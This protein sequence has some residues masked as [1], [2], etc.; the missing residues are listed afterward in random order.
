MK[1]TEISLRHPVA[2]TVLA[3]TVAVIGFFS[4][5]T[6][7]V[8]YLP[9]VTYPLIR[10]Q[11]WWRG[12]TPEDIETSIAEP[13]ER[14]MAT[15]ENLD[16][17]ESS[18]IE[19]MYTLLVNFGYGADVDVAY[20][21]V[22]AAMGRATRN[23]PPD[24][25][26]PLVFKADPSQLP[27]LELTV[28]SD[29]RNPVWLRDWA[30]HWLADRLTAVDGTAG[31]EVLGGLKREIR[32]LLDPLRLQA[33]GVDV[34]RVARVLFESN[35]ELFAGRV[36]VG[37][38]EFIARTVGEFT[39]IDEIENVVVARTPAGQEVRV[40]D[41]ARVEDSHEDSRIITRLDGRP[42]VKLR[43]LKQARANTVQV[44]RDV[45][46]RMDDLR[47]DIP[48]DI[49]VAI[50]E[51]QGD[52]VNAAIN[53][54]Q[55]SALLAALLVLVI[56]YLFLGRWRQIIVMVVALPLT[57][58]ACFLVM[59]LAGFSLNLFSLGGL[60][61]SLGVI[62]DNSIVVLENV[63]RRKADGSRAFALEGT[64]EVGTAVVAATITFLAIFLPFLFIP[65]LTALLFREL[66]LVI[67]AVVV[68][69]LLVALVVTPLISDRLLR[70]ERTGEAPRLTRGFDGFIR[71]L[72]G[73]YARMLVAV[74]RGRWPVAGVFL[75]L[76]ALGL[77]LAGRAG[78]E[79]LP[80]VDD[81]RVMVKVKMP[82]GT[83]VERVD[84]VMRSAER[85][86]ADIPEIASMFTLTG[87]LTR[88]LATYEIAEE[89]QIDI[90]LVPKG[91]RRVSSTEFVN[92][93][94]P[95]LAKVPA[96]G[97][98]VM[99][100]QPKT[101]GIRQVGEQ[102]VE[103]KVRG[104]VL[105]DIHAFAREIA[106]SLRQADGL[107][108]VS[109][110]LEIAKPE[111]RVHI[112][113][114]RASALGV[115][116]N[117]VATSLRTLVTG[118]VATRY[119]ENDEY[120]NIRVLVPEEYVTCKADMENLTVTTATGATVHLRDIAEVHRAVGPVEISREDQVKQVIVR[121][122]AEAI[123]V[124][125]A[126]NRAEG[127]VR[128]L[129]RP[130][131]IEYSM[132]G[133]AQMIAENR[134][135]MTLLV[136][137]ALLFA[138]TVLAVQFESLRLPLLILL[139]IPFSLTGAFAALYLSGAAIGTTVLIGLVVMMG[140]ITSQGVVLLT[141][142]EQHRREGMRPVDAVLAAAPVRLR[143]ILMTQLTTVIGLLPLA[144][145]LGE[146]GDL[147]K[148]MAIAVIGGLL[149]SLAVTLF[150]LPVAYALVMGRKTPAVSA[151]N[152][153]G[154]EPTT[155]G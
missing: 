8:D 9:D 118:T 91:K 28:A 10:V 121:A 115:S 66:V 27:V 30:E 114:S 6:L 88:G 67:A 5:Q 65:G 48:P 42:C 109:I 136:L 68:I 84:S 116:V 60:V 145:N 149:Y 3:V 107:T 102:A 150:F 50:L 63:T 110:S 103:V 151:A 53:S 85:E 17:L 18:S 39:S 38:R 131:G 142:A 29:E 86:I 34:F 12:A 52:Y 69:S 135:S 93:L 119:R 49:R 92:R 40:A 152:S 2:V 123:S 73:G 44:A 23:L 77:F 127:A 130:A 7:A 95:V 57:L 112:D 137:F 54:V 79:F 24:I 62:L 75:V 25:D 98:R 101:R 139:G 117:Q 134:H 31:V 15:V 147:L 108:N 64:R 72:T 16:Y 36:V 71:F 59:R 138:F 146:G 78:S 41:L 132:G 154:R 89:G 46:R 1:L 82:T 124:G 111:F 129:V 96:P 47:G 70:H 22:L 141:L 21:D 113:R 20:Q 100:M 148:P 83:S 120:Y 126:V 105:A 43:V 80:L 122:D 140:G 58:L 81:G 33:Y 26:P 128:R 11:V 125:E 14:A 55:W 97:G 153:R 99:A 51:N 74:Q 144:L 45:Q 56:V 94:R 106:A 104:A 32:V 87:G 19:G 13:V 61:V 76:F 143:P 37:D 4:L 90:Q 35:R 133:Q 155:T